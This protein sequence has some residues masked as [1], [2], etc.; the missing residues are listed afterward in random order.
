MSNYDQHFF[1]DI[2]SGSYRS[3]V[4]VSD[5]LLPIVP[6]RSV[7]DIGC[8]TGAW[9]RAFEEH[10]VKEI[11]GYDGEYVQKD[12]LEIAPSSFCAKNICE[13]DSIPKKFDL[14]LCLEVLEHL[15][16]KVGKKIVRLMC[17]TTP[18]VL[19]SAAIPGQGGTNHVNER[20]HD[21]WHREFQENGFRVIDCIRPRILTNKEVEL[22]YR[23]NIFLYASQSA[24]EKYPGLLE[25][26]E[27]QDYGISLIST[28]HFSKFT[29]CSGLLDAL[30]SSVYRKIFKS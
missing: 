2:L 28:V 19:F 15:P 18:L 1:N 11:M 26:A 12:V 5:I 25:L 7:V 17:N 9:L 6:V 4:V 30:K 24:F 29:Y 3:A 14:A 23:Q 20:W 16:D 13:L 8:G 21:Y 10:G 22:W 27:N